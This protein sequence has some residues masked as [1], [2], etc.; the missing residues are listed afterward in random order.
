MLNVL[1]IS[2]ELEGVSYLYIQ[3]TQSNIIIHLESTYR[4]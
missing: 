2:Y 1:E 4:I 3:Q